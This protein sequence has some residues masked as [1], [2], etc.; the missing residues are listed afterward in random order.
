MKQ[1][2]ASGHWSKYWAGGNLTSLPQDFV[3][4]YDG[5]IAEFWHAQFRRI[6]DHGKLLDVCTGNGAVVLLAAAWSRSESRSLGLFGV[7]AAR[8]DPGAIA[9]RYPSQAG[10]L[11]S[12]KLISG[13]RVEDIDLPPGTFDL[14]TSQYGIEYC[15]WSLAAAQVSRLL[16]P[17]GRFAFLSH[18]VS[19]GIIK[20][21][22]D[23]W[24][25][26]EILQ[27]LEFL[28]AIEAYLQ[29][30]TDFPEFQR[31]M[32]NSQ[33]VVSA[34]Y[35][36]LN[37]PFLGSILNMLANV[38]PMDQAALEQSRA[39]LDQFQQEISQ[40][41]QRLKDLLRV[42]RAIQSDAG[43]YRVFEQHGLE[44]VD[45]GDILYKGVH[46]SGRYYCFVKPA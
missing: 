19:T 14:V 33:A 13:C 18:A 9:A 24:R 8:I 31:T 27:E 34:E 43:W 20:Y 37:S 42:N 44:L 35:R 40:G 32:K 21:M 10:L 25:E 3:A 16:K 23:E 39:R 26:Y 30:K 41:R 28:S 29:G 6:P 5:E 45:E 46:N 12:I 1:L 22:E 11:S 17:G 38:V 36:R 7:D 2:P 15:D 4:N